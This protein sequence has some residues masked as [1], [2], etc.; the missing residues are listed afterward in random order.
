MKIRKFLI[1]LYVL[2]LGGCATYQEK[3]YP[4]CNF[5]CSD[6]ISEPCSLSENELSGLKT[7][8][9][10]HNVSADI[11][12]ISASAVVIGT[13]GKSAHT[14]VKKIWPYFVCYAPSVNNTLSYFRSLTCEDNAQAWIELADS[15]TMAKLLKDPKYRM[16]CMDAI[17]LE[18]K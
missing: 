9:A 6:Q 18:D 12:R 4:I 17:L 13:R 8:L 3:P 2:L 7:A 14:T 11:I 1:S 15:N 5:R 10:Q 16:T